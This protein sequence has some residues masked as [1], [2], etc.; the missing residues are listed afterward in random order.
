MNTS[1]VTDRPHRMRKLYSLPQ[2][3]THFKQITSPPST[4]A[5]TGADIIFDTMR[6]LCC[7]GVGAGAG[8]IFDTVQMR[9]YRDFQKIRIRRYDYI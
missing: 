8:I 7:T 5:G 3:N 9:K 4:G 6:V 1:A 2:P